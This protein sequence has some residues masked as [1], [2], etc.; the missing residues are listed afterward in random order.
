[1]LRRI[2]FPKIGSSKL[3]ILE[4][5][6]DRDPPTENFKNFKFFQH[7]RKI[8]NVYFWGDKVYFGEIRFTFGEVRFTLGDSRRCFGFWNLFFVVGGGGLG[9]CGSGG[10]VGVFKKRKYRPQGTSHVSSE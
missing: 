7:F 10:P 8:L 4:T 9:L 1:M 5:P 6:Y 3:D 2:P